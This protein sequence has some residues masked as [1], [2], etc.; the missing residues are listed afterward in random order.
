MNPLFALKRWHYQRTRTPYVVQL[1]RNQRAVVARVRRRQAWQHRRDQIA[2]A[3]HTAQQW[4]VTRGPAVA[5]LMAVY[6]CAVAVTVFVCAQP[7]IDA[8]QAEIASIRRDRDVWRD[9]AT[10]Q[11]TNEITVNLRGNATEV[12]RSVKRIAEDM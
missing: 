8:Q 7:V 2:H 11:A 12:R 6:A 5:G 1:G 4:L 10:R 9:V 3:V